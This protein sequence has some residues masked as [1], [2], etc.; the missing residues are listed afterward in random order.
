MPK[1]VVLIDDCTSYRNIVG[2]LLQAAGHTV[3]GYDNA[4]QAERD[5]RP[6]EF[7]VAILDA[8]HR[9]T[10]GDVFG[11]RNKEQRTNHQEPRINNKQPAT[12]IAAI[13]Q[14]VRRI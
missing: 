13:H 11:T 10:S 14:R 4:A 8:H 3:T 1:Q 7:D 2:G 9:G 12:P 5:L 6:R